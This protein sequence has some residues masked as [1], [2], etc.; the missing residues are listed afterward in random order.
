PHQGYLA[1]RDP[2]VALVLA[3]PRV[4]DFRVRLYRSEPP[5]HQGDLG[6][7]VLE[8][9]FDDDLKVVVKLTAPAHCYLIAY[10]PDGE[11]QL[12]YPSDG[13]V[14]P[15]PKQDLTY[16]NT[17]DS[18]F[19]LNDGL[20]V[21]AFVLLVSRNPLPTFDLWKRAAGKAPWKAF[22]ADGV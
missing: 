6:I 12:C 3:R 17:E 13:S 7:T 10:N 14:A 20:G 2:Q 18:Y 11:E 4:D 1:N 16:P 9:R 21:Q 22:T 8:A 15:P 5:K 19:G